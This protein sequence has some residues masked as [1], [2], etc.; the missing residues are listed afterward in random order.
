MTGPRLS[1]HLV[2]LAAARRFSSD[3]AVDLVVVME[4]GSGRLPTRVHCDATY[5]SCT[6]RRGKTLP[7]RRPIILQKLPPHVLA[8]FIPR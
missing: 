3:V 5:E 4:V 7:V 8:V 1:S 2:S 6:D